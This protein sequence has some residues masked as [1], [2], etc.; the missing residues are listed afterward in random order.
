[1]NRTKLKL[2]LKKEFQVNKK[3]NK[4]QDTRNG[5]KDSSLDIYLKSSAVITIYMYTSTELICYLFKSFIVL[6][7]SFL[8]VISKPGITKACDYTFMLKSMLTSNKHAK[9]ILFGHTCRGYVDTFG[10]IAPS[11]IYSNMRL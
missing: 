5:Q 11:K 2:K 9:L 6:C 10:H 4:H 8:A 7:A 3:H 1:M